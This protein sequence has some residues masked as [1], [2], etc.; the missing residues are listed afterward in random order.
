[1][2]IVVLFPGQTSRDPAMIE[3]ALSRSRRSR[4]LL[5][6][7]SEL[8]DSDLA[9]HYRSDNPQAF[10]TNEAIQLGVFL[11]NHL[12]LESLHDHGLTT[13]FSVGASLGEY[14]HLV[15]IGALS[16]EDAL[17]AVQRRGQLFDAA[18][19]GRMSALFPIDADALQ[20]L[21]DR[22][23]CSGLVVISN[24]N[25]PRQ[26]VIAGEDDAV[27][28]VERLAEREFGAFALAVDSEIAMH[29]PLMEG[30][31][32]RFRPILERLE[33]RT[34]RA[35]Y[36]PGVL[37]CWL[38]GWSRDAV[39]DL[40][41]RHV[42][43]PIYFRQAIDHLARELGPHVAFVE[44]GCGG[45]LT[46]LLRRRWMSNAVSLDADELVVTELVSREA[47]AVRSPDSRVDPGPTQ[48]P[49]HA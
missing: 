14:N 47:S 33:W 27:V 49:A 20:P 15:H 7:A 17:F 30:V 37:G 10:S 23:S 26:L 35:P 21:I 43:R 19:K 38:R 11:A 39:V 31:A 24:H 28:Q 34:P 4:H 6:H 25:S 48:E 8:V 13:T 42:S 5:Q 3:R 32:E 2:S 22:C 40:L 12:A 29:S 1:M 41:V 46:A 45:A 16:F 9:A 36:L 44:A 18:P